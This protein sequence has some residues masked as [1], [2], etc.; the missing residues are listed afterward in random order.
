MGNHEIFRI[1]TEISPTFQFLKRG[2][3]KRRSELKRFNE[4]SPQI[5]GQTLETTECYSTVISH[6][7]SLRS[8]NNTRGNV[9]AFAINKSGSQ[10]ILR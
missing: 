5:A 8:L 7:T 10:N 6:I 1:H 3:G 9:A 4:R 2:C